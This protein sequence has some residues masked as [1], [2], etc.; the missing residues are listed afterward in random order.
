MQNNLLMQRYSQPHQSLSRWVAHYWGWQIPAG[1]GLPDLFPGTG[2]EVLFNLGAPLMFS[3]FPLSTDGEQTT[4]RFMVP[5]G[6]AVLLRP[7]KARLKIS[8]TGEID[9]LSIRLRSATSFPLF[10]FALDE[11][12]D[13]PIP[14]ADL[15]LFF[16][17]VELLGLPY[18]TRTSLLE[19]WLL[20][21]CMRCHTT[22]SAMIW[23]IDRLY[24]GEDLWFI[25]QQ[26]GM[27]ER[28]MQRR[29]RQFTGVDARYFCRTARFQRA[30]RQLLTESPIYCN[31][32]ND[33]YFDQSHFIKTCRL[34]TGLTPSRLLTAQF[35]EL[36]YYLPARLCPLIA[37]GAIADPKAR[38]Q[39]GG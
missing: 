31:T 23:A 21:L 14:L 35:R 9:I 26:L 27:N 33:D 34:Y 30:L 28:T 11:L 20:A 22:D 38:Y 24:Y 5:T 8:A 7:R 25:R 32:N 2:G 13:M 10:G 1:R 17:A 3:A 18:E 15:G 39:G 36:N 4:Y 16:P 37:R 6:E 29:I 19:Q 12:S